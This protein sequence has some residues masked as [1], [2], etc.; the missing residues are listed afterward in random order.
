MRHGSIELYGPLI[1]QTPEGIQVGSGNTATRPENANNGV[2]RFNNDLQSL[3][4]VV[5]GVWLNVGGGGSNGGANT[6]I[7]AIAI[8]YTNTAVNAA[9]ITS[10]HYTDNAFANSITY[11]NTILLSANNYTNTQI[12][13]GLAM[14]QAY[15]NSQ[16]TY[17]ITTSENYTNSVLA[18]VTGH[19][20]VANN[21]SNV[22]TATTTLNFTG[23]GVTVSNVGG[24]ATV[25]IIRGSSGGSA[26]TVASNSN[27]VSNA[28]TYLNF[29]DKFNVNQSNSIINID[30]ANS[31]G[32]S[33]YNTSKNGIPPFSDFTSYNPGGTATI[34]HVEGKAVELYM[35]GA[36]QDNIYFYKNAP[37]T[38]Y[39]IVSRLDVNY[40]PFRSVQFNTFGIGWYN[41]SS[42]AIGFVGKCAAQGG[43]NHTSLVVRDST[44]WNFINNSEF[45]FQGPVYFAIEDDGT[46]IY[47]QYSIN[48]LTWITL[49]SVAKSSG[50]VGD[51]THP[52]IYVSAYEEMSLILSLWDENGLTR[53]INDVIDT[54]GGSGGSGS[55]TNVALTSNTLS[56]SGSP[57]TSSGV[58]DV[59]LQNSGVTP[60]SYNHFTVNKYGLITNASTS[61]SAASLIIKHNNTVVSNAAVSLNF[62]GNGVSVSDD[63]LGNSTI[64]I[65]SSTS[66][67]TSNASATWIPL[68]TG[69]DPPVLVSD[70][71]GHLIIIAFNP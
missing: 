2:I 14:S 32:G 44:Y 4:T 54:A 28:A 46:T 19:L 62:T 63:G 40:L 71:D 31:T 55:V 70:G 26:L 29:S 6:E 16:V 34:T 50:G 13:S 43:D 9:I 67:S 56:I 38:P 60:G 61:N 15:T 68:V 24:V 5:D 18:N 41:T 47:Y 1:Q 21:G 59:E 53:G 20:T 22:T 23:N 39:R 33:F 49:Y 27:V 65:N 3:E 57:I 17:A 7:L 35:S 11:S 10:E 25:N 66:N 8:A 51:Y 30:L 37:S 64:T 36:S 45:S 58:I 69:A 52:F 12:S 42:G 48:S